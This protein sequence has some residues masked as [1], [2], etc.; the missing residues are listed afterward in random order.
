MDEGKI[1]QP[2]GRFIAWA[3]IVECEKMLLDDKALRG[4][5]AYLTDPVTYKSLKTTP[6]VAGQSIPAFYRWFG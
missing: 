6:A 4:S 2:K 3:D 5:L 1:L